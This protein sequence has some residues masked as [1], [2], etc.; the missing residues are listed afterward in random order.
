MPEKSVAA[1]NFDPFSSES[2][3]DPYPTY[4][5]LLA[6]APVFHNAERD[7]WAISRFDD[8]KGLVQDWERLSSAQGVRI[9]DLLE[10]AG[11][12]PLTMDP[13]RHAL[14]RA[15]V[16]KPFTHRAMASLE[17]MVERSVNELLDAISGDT[18]D[19]ISEFAKLVPVTIICHLLGVPPHDARM[20]KSWADA[21]LETVPGVQGSTPEAI[22]GA[23]NLRTYWTNAIDERR[24]HP[25]DDILS[26]LAVSEVHG[27]PVPL[28][29]QVGMC[30]LIFEAGNATTGTLIGNALLALATHPGERDWLEATPEAMPEA[31][32]EFLRWE[33]PV[34]TLMRVTMTPLTLHGTTI[35]TGSRVL[36][37]LG[38][39]NRDPRV[40]DEPDELRLSRPVQRNLGFG[41]GIHHCLGAPLAR[42]EAPIALRAFLERFPSY[43]V[44]S[45]ERFNDVTLRA[46]RSLQ[47]H[48]N[49]R[50]AS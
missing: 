50:G 28:D 24:A 6:E 17:P 15:L 44:V 25:G 41:E 3:T 46:L 4:Q 9:D 36:L 47:V 37:V 22:T 48:A 31:I 13:P 23:R 49:P 26:V 20:L 42:L 7:V 40:W 32:E 30:N 8:V 27:V 1:I 18:F 5:R 12:S 21:M 16:R 43:D 11:P 35:P 45:S 19:A 33:S 29:E 14:L 38:A 2:I 39:A 34:Q 10:L